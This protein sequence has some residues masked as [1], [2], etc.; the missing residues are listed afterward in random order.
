VLTLGNERFTTARCRYTDA[1]GRSGGT[2]KIGVKVQLGDWETP[3]L[4]IL[5]TGADWSVLNTETAE[6]LDLFAV[7]GEPITLSTRFGRIAGYLVQAPVILLA[8]DG[9]S[10]RV[11]AT[12]FIS[13][14]WPTRAGTFLGYSGLLE[15]IRF[16]VDPRNNNLFFG[17]VD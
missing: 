7:Q 16:A 4:A 8:D 1:D 10:L 2:A 3:I 13:T 11:D 17:P 14:D 12:V 15:R 6:E 5:D 9:D